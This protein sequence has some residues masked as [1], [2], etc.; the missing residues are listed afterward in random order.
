V[1]PAWAG[2]VTGAAG[3][4]GV[5]TPA[6]RAKVAALARD[7]SPDVQL[8]IAIAS[9]KIKNFDALPVL[10]DV[11]A[12]CGQDK[13]IPSIAWN[14]LHP[15]LETEGTRFVSLQKTLPPALAALSPRI[16]ERILSGQKP[17]GAAVGALIKFV[18]AFDDQHA[19]ECL[20]AVSSKLGAL[21]ESAIAQLK[22]HLKPLLK[23][24]HARETDTPLML[25]A[26]LLA[27]RLGLAQV[28]PAVIRTRFTSAGLPRRQR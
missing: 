12:H 10:S 5:V 28:D 24:L 6:V 2:N 16:V 13:L 23:D 15:L 17:D 22:A 1:L 25:S 21:S 14:N 9:R 26:Q 27:A 19:K 8:Q 7:P 20:S 18:A 11:L 4:L 3:N